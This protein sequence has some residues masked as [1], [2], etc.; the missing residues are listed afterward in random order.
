M[1]NFLSAIDDRQGC[2]LSLGG[3]EKLSLSKLSPLK[4][5][6]RARL[7]AHL[8]LLRLQ[9]RFSQAA[10]P[11]ELARLLEDYLSL[12]GLSEADLKSLTGADLLETYLTLAGLNSWQWVLPWLRPPDAPGL[13]P[14]EHAKEP[15]YHYAGRHWAIWIHKI[16]WAYGWSRDQILNLWPEEAAAYVQEIIIAEYD[17]AEEQRALSELSYRHNKHSN[18]MQFI[19]RPRPHWMVDNALPPPVRVRRD[20]LPVGNVIEI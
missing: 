12:A 7:G 19:P 9:A 6:S 11:D 16:A 5:I 4:F 14:P 10:G 13:K 8:Q 18:L 3:Q 20:M 15:P 2:W 1:D 17:Q